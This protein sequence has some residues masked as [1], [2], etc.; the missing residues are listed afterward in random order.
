MDT[1]DLGLLLPRILVDKPFF[2]NAA[3]MLRLMGGYVVEKRKI[4]RCINMYD[5]SLI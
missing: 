2:K 5:V 4:K 1:R 3:G